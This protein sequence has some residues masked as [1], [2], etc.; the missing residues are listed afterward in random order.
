MAGTADPSRDAGDPA[1]EVRLEGRVSNTVFFSRDSRYTVLRVYVSGEAEPSTWVGRSLGVEDGA[2]VSAAGE[3]VMHPVHGRQFSF[4]RLVV[5]A[6]TTLPGIQRR[7]EKYP[8]LGKDK[9]DKIVRRFGA[10]TFTILDKQPRRL[11]EIEGI[12]PKTLERVLEYHSSRSGP[13]VEVEN[14]LVELDLPA[15]HAEALVRRYNADALTVLRRHPYRLAREVR[16][17]GFLTADRIA[18][19]L[20]V[21]MESDD[22]IDA[23]LLYVLEQAE[24]DGHCA[25]PRERLVHDAVRL[26]ALPAGRDPQAMVLSDGIPPERVDAGIGR[27]LLSGDLIEERRERGPA[28]LFPAHLH[29]AEEHVAAILAELAT[30]TAHARWDPGEL[31]SHLSP[32]QVQ[33]V[34]AIAE[35]GLVILTGGPGTG[36]STVIRQVIEMA[37]RHECELMLAAPTGRAAKRLAEATGQEARTIHR[38]LEI[39]GSSGA[40]TYHAN[41]PL[42]SPALVVIDEASMLDLPLAEALFTALTPEHR[43]MLVGDVDQL[44]SVGPGNVLRDVIAAADRA[45]SPIPVVRLTQIF[46]QAEGSSIIVNAHTILEG[47]RLQPDSGGAGQFFVVHARDA[48]RA[49]EL[50]MKAVCERAPEAYGLDPRTEVQILCPMHKGRAGTAAFNKALQERFTAGNPELVTEAVGRAQPRV[51]RVGDRVMQTRNDYERGVFNGDIGQVVSVSPDRGTLV[52][53]VDGL[54]VTYEQKQLPALQLAYAVTIHKSQG[55]E[56]PAVIIPLLGEH[57]VMLRRNLLYTAVTRAQRLCV[58]V[59][60]PRAIAQAIRRA[61]AARRFTGLGERLS[62]AIRGAMGELEII[63]VD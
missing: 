9:A 49:H 28:L 38:L 20:G 42:P 59:G 27:L 30:T 5:K 33:A 23:G 2:Q 36:K 61:D 13:L 39:Q 40:F 22:R 35:A 41:N 62:A 54:P 45:G 25:L 55:S 14:Q 43:L 18:R 44:P 34:R 10:D 17:I 15:H 11:L 6:P 37:L 46:R 48:E 26:L 32:G 53:E 50:V 12:G 7:L 60:D 56:F 4:A 57:Y 51:F 47:G 16:G 31:P 19:A 1:S 29:A 58:L 24:S 8:G 63:D 52:V 3:W 21:D